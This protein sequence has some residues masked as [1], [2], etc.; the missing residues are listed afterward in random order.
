MFCRQSTGIAAYVIGGLMLVPG[1]AQVHPLRAQ[2]PATAAPEERPA[3]A[4]VLAQAH[5]IADSGRPADALRKLFAAFED[6]PDDAWAPDDFRRILNRVQDWFAKLPK[7][8]R[9]T[10]LAEYQGTH[11]PGSAS[12][13]PLQQL[14]AWLSETAPGTSLRSPGARLAYGLCNFVEGNYLQ[15]IA[16]AMGVFQQAPNSVAA[17]Y[18]IVNLMGMQY[19]RFDTQGM[20]R[21][22]RV[23][24]GVAPDNP[25][26]A[27]ALCAFTMYLCSKGQSQAARDLCGEIRRNAPETL[28]ARVA[29]QTLGLLDMIES[30]AYSAAIDRF[31]QLRDF[32]IPIPG[33]YVLGTLA[34]GIDWDRWR[35]DSGA[36]QRIDLLLRAAEAELSRNPDPQRRA[37]ALLIVGH[38]FQCQGNKRQAAEYFQQAAD[39]GQPGAE[40]YG[41][42][43]A[44][45]NWAGID[46]KRAIAALERFRKTHGRGGGAETSLAL[47][48]SLYRKEG[49]YEEGLQLFLEL[50]ERCRSGQALVDVTS[51][52]LRAGIVGCLRG[53]GREA[54]AAALADPLLKN[55][56]YGGDVKT[57]QDKQLGELYGLLKDMGRDQEAERMAQE[58]LCRARERQGQ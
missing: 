3:L 11:A 10:L 35:T 53:L 50:E 27:W 21:T 30:Q 39:T 56:G 55:R 37:C 54:E 23:A 58:L 34:M 9:R 52:S 57:I 43:R 24:A 51:E 5:A 49:R 41:L 2:E 18:A 28:V 42:S 12:G 44:G 38:C 7:S 17:G 14:T 15:F 47:L 40:E 45:R 25:R 46:P 13:A 31:W 33:Q 4:D 8:E 26:T 48:A 29:D 36:K 16:S 20:Y 19:Y 6:Y 32:I 1:G 22:V